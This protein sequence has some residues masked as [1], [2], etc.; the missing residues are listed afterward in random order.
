MIIQAQGSRFLRQ[1]LIPPIMKGFWIQEWAH[2]AGSA[3]CLYYLFN[4]FLYLCY[5]KSKYSLFQDYFLY[6]EGKLPNQPFY[7]EVIWWIN[8]NTKFALKLGQVGMNFY[9]HSC[10]FDFDII[11]YPPLSTL[12]RL[13]SQLLCL[14]RLFQFIVNLKGALDQLIVA[15]YTAI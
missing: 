11:I 9:R 5:V 4:F 2:K 8:N 1:I 14:F 12:K 15:I 7:G 13:R 6:S 10:K 3:T